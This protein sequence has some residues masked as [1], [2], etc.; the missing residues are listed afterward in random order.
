MNIKLYKP[1]DVILDTYLV[2]DVRSG[3]MGNVYSPLEPL[4]NQRHIHASHS[5]VSRRTATALSGLY[6]RTQ[7][8]E[9]EACDQGTE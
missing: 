4:M 8:V 2:D 3:G 5:G 1:G 7:E 6:R 9:A